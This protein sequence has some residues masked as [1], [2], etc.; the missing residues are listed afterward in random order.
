MLQHCGMKETSEFITSGLPAI[1]S[2]AVTNLLMLF[3]CFV[4]SIKCQHPQNSQLLDDWKTQSG[5]NSHELVPSKHSV[6]KP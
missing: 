6:L 1:S 4:C 5:L 3:S 2:M